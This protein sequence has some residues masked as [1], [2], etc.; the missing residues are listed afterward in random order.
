MYKGDANTSRVV[1]HKM[2]DHSRKVRQIWRSVCALMLIGYS[3]GLCKADEAQDAVEL[4][5]Y[6]FRCNVAVPGPD[7]MTTDDI[8]YIGNQ[9]IFRIVTETTT[10]CNDNGL[11][12]ICRYSATVAFRFA[13]LRGVECCGNGAIVLL[14]CAHAN[15]CI[16]EAGGRKN[17]TS[18]KLKNNYSASF[19]DARTALNV[20]AAIE[21]LIRINT[22]GG[23]DQH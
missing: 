19:C 10:S 13:A 9:N 18:G 8:H 1:T 4:L 12:P 16:S 14:T 20:K 23:T 7:S 21:T 11:P 2:A 17:P 6:A 5:T 3:S 22:D 15:A